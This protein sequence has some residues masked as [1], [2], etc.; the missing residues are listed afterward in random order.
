MSRCHARARALSSAVSL[1]DIT[2]L[3][4]GGGEDCD[5][6]PVL[7]TVHTSSDVLSNQI[8]A[9]RQLLEVL[10]LLAYIKVLFKSRLQVCLPH[11]NATILLGG[12][13]AVARLS[14]PPH[15]TVLHCYW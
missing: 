2:A 6:V 14:A 13:S 1:R 9:G 10:K 15:S 11:R 3:G 12:P 7:I 8:T 4:V 5:I